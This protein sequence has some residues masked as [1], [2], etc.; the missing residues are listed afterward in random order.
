M[1]PIMLG[2]QIVHM[3][4]I[5]QTVCS[6]C[7]GDSDANQLHVT[8]ILILRLHAYGVLQTICWEI[9]FKLYVA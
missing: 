7:W 9:L 5:F 8:S 2:F 6:H 3:L 1:L 4:E